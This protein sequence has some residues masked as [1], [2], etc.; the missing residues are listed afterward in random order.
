MEGTMGKW[1]LLGDFNDVRVPEERFNSEFNQGNALV[2]NNFV[3]V[4]G[5]LEYQMGGRKFTFMSGDGQ[6]LS[7]IDR[8]FVCE[9]FMES[10]PN[11]KLTA[12][13]RDVSDHSPLLLSIREDGIGPIPFR[14]FNSWL[15]EQELDDLVNRGMDMD[16]GTG[17]ADLRMGKKLKATKNLI[18]AWR[19]QKKDIE[20]KDFE[21]AKAMVQQLECLAEVR[22]L[23]EEERK[24]WK[25]NKLV[26]RNFEWKRL[27]DIHQKAKIDWLLHGD[28]NSKFFHGVV[29]SKKARNK[30][31]GLY[32]NG[33]WESRPDV[34]KE[35]VREFFA[36]KYREP[37]EMRPKMRGDGFSKL[38]DSEAASLIEPFSNEE[39]RVAVWEC[40]NDKSPGPDGFS[41]AFVRHYWEKLKPHV[42]GIMDE[43]FVHGTISKSVNSSFVALIP[44]VLDPMSLSD[45]R[46]ISLIGVI[47]KIVSKVLANRLKKVLGSI[48]SNEQSAF[49]KGGNILDGPLIINEVVNWA[50]RSK[51]KIMVFKVD[52]EKAYDCVSWKFLINTMRHMG[53]PSRWKNWIMG[54]LFT[55]RA[56]V[57]INGSPTDEFEIKRGLR[58]GDPLS[59]FLFTIVME[60]LHVMVDKATKAELFK[61]VKI[62]REGL[63][64]S[65]L[66]YADDALFL[67]N[68]SD[69]NFRILNRILRCFQMA[70]GLKVNLFKSKVYGV[71]VNDEEVEDLA[72]ILGCRKGEF[73]FIYLGL[74]VGANMNRMASWK[75]V[76]DRFNAKLSF[77]KA[78]MLSFAGRVTLIKSVLGS[79]ENYYLSLFKA[80]IGVIK[81]LK[82]IRRRF[83]WGGSSIGRK[84]RWVAWDRIL[85]SKKA[86]GLGVGGI[87]EMNLG[88]ISKWWWRYK[89]CKNHLWNKVID[90]IHGGG[91]AHNIIPSKNSMVGVWK[92]IV[93]VNKEFRKYNLDLNDHLAG[94][95]GKG[96]TVRFWYDKWC[97]GCRLK[98][99]FPSIYTISKGKHGLVSEFYNRGSGGITWELKWIRRPSSAVELDELQRIMRLL[100]Q[101]SITDSN[102]KWEWVAQGVKSEFSVKW[103]RTDL[104]ESTNTCTR[105]PLFKWSSLAVP[106]V[107]HFVWRAFNGNI[108]TASALAS[109]NVNAD[110]LLVECSFAKTVWWTVC[111]WVRIPIP[112]RFKS[113]RQILQHALNTDMDH[114]WK[115]VVYAIFLFTLWKLWLCRNDKVFKGKHKSASRIVEE[116]KEGTYWWM[117]K[118]CK[119]DGLNT[120]SW[121]KF[122]GLSFG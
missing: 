54:I 67:G 108:P 87:K 73:P 96:D 58:Q 25:D 63:C 100:G 111:V 26:T 85:S 14:F 18:K 82:G 68:W 42:R 8:V 122:E 101:A 29:N 34:I 98:D 83:L 94:E 69:E 107:N 44:K 19:R 115:R 61:G 55:G 78:R 16:A 37:E 31:D 15:G 41:F 52:F 97:Q 59:P 50:R 6:R 117:A 84:I 88:L 95:V 112:S 22:I 110:H 102:D 43:F 47:S 103:V 77:W 56:S 80:P 74:P 65:H 36:K 91:R 79:M 114:K 71:G 5:L 39:I 75:A 28:E 105:Q 13:E 9:H 21:Q 93:A 7:K 106:K 46:P 104:E 2:F 23:S 70:S 109:R 92:A 35:E 45:F 90:E 116:I 3:A 53:F 24:C 48:I 38:S 119:M 33:A 1:I 81:T 99:Q 20:E 118:R 64:L 89:I 120:D 30:I 72:N 66:F 60:A 49:I 4:A 86:G 40:G 113:V 62:T 32:L 12:L 51:K 11:A 27:Q 76:V 17:P 121:N 57:L 10:W